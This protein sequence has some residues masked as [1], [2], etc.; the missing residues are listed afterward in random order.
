MD[1]TFYDRRNLP[2]PDAE[3]RPETDEDLVA[4]VGGGAE[5]ERA[6]VFV[7]GGEHLAAS[8][9][10]ERRF[11]VVR[12]DRLD[13]IRRV[14]RR[15]LTVRLEAGVRW[16]QLRDELRDEGL[17][18]Q[19]YG[20]YP[21]GATVGGLLARRQPV[22]AGFGDGDIRQGCIGLRSVAPGADG[23]D[24]L[25]APRKATGP[26]HRYLYIGGE[27]A[28]GAI[29]EATLVV[30]RRQ[31]GM[32]LR[33]PAEGPAEA[34]TAYRRLRHLDLAPAWVRWGRE[35]DRLEVALYAPAPLLEAHE[36]RLRIELDEAVEF[37]GG[38]AADQRR[39]ELE[40]AAGG[41]RSSE[42]AEGRLQ[43]VWR[44]GD[45][46]PAL[47][48]LPDGVEPV[49]IDRWSAQSARV[50]LDLPDEETAIDPEERALDIRRVVDDEERV[51]SAWLQRLK[52]RLD[53]DGRLAVGP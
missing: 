2:L 22:E 48:A 34:V 7:G 31:P 40:S 42:G 9:I 16:G 36:R 10:G 23:Y 11:D 26:D 32:L 4:L 38:E 53:P 39:G 18:L 47:E 20:L 52:R 17:S 3:H 19:N 51:W 25:P 35:S 30:G 12:T 21:A 24:Y 49:A 5:R 44:L 33:L 45:I 6:F 29:L 50:H 14:D 43:V 46:D 8:A 28:V 41:A 13:R 27:G 37:V 1:E 15:S